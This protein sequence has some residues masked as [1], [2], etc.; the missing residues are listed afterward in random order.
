MEEVILR[1]IEHK[2]YIIRGQ[3]VMLVSDLAELYGVET[4][5]LNRQVRRN[6]IRFPDDCAPRMCGGNMNTS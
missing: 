3:K 2:I 5:A 6:I 1:D 4:K